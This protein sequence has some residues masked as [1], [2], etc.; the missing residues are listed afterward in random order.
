MSSNCLKIG[1][2]GTFS[3]P[4]SYYGKMLKN[5]VEKYLNKDIVV[6]YLDDEATVEK[7]KWVAK[8]FIDM[9]V[10]LVIGH[11]NGECSVFCKQKV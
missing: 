2:A 5:V 1:V 10:H 3:G 11:F 7:A 9:K 8:K 4:R 6:Y